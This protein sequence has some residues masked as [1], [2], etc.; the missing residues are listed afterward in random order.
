MIDLFI[1]Y[2]NTIF[3]ARF[4]RA[5]NGVPTTEPMR[6]YSISST[7]FALFL[8]LIS[9]ICLG[10]TQTV[11]SQSPVTFH[12]TDEVVSQGEIFL[13]L[14]S[15][16]Q[17][18]LSPQEQASINAQNAHSQG[19]AYLAELARQRNEPPFVVDEAQAAATGPL[20]QV[21]QWGPIVQWPFAFASAAT[22]PDGRII[23]WGA[24]N[25]RRFSGGNFT[26]ASIWDPATGQFLSRNHNDHP[27]FCAIPTM[28]EDGRLF[29][30]GG[31]ANTNKVST[32]D[33]RTNQW[34]RVDNMNTGRWYPGSVALPNGKVFTMLGRPGGP[35][36]EVWTEGQGWSLQTGANLNNGVLNY[37]GYQSTWLPYLHLMP[38]GN[39]LHSGPTTQMNILDPSGNGSIS[40]AG[41]TNS[42]YPKYSTGIMYDEGK[43]LVAGGAASSSSTAPGTNQAMIID[44]NGA[45][46][47]KTV[48]A[49]MHYARKF[50]NGVVLPTG[51]VLVIGGNTSGREFSDVGTIL[52]P[53][54]WNPTTQTW[55]EVA[56]MSVPR[57]YHSV[58]LLMTDGRVWSGGGGLCNCSADHMDHQVYSPPYLFNADGSPA[59]R[60]AITSGPAAATNGNVIT[61]QASADIQQFSLIKMSGTT[62]DLKSDLHYTNVP[63]TSPNSGE[64]QLT[65]HSNKNVLTPGFWMLFAINGQGTPSVAKVIQI[66]SSGAPQ[67]VSPGDQTNDVGD[68]VALQISANGPN[69]NAFT[70]SATG[71]PAG[72]SISSSGL[73]AGTVN[74]AGTYN[75]TITVQGNGETDSSSFVWNINT[76]P[77]SGSI[78]YVKLVADSEVNG[79]PWTSAAEFNVLDSNENVIDRSGWSITADSEET[80]GEDGRATNAIDGNTG[81]IWH[82]QWQA[83]DPPHPHQIVVDMGSGHAVKGFRYL[84]RQIGAINGT[85]AAY[86]FY[87]STDGAN[88]GSPVAQGTFAN[89]RDEK[90]VTF[91][92]TGAN[93]PPVLASPG[94]QNDAVGAT[95]SLAVSANDPDGD[96]MAFSATGLPTGLSIDSA[97]GQIG[98]T[99]SASGS[100]NVTVAV[101][102]G[103]GGSDSVSFTWSIY[104]ALTLS[105]LEAAPQP[106]GAAINYTAGFNNGSNPRFKWLF[107]DNTA[108]TAYSSSPSISHTFAEPGRYIVT[109]TATDDSGQEVTEQFAQLIHRPLTAQQPALSMSIVYETRAGNDRIWNV[110]PD[111]DTVSVTDAVT[112]QKVVE[113]AVGSNPR[114]LAVAPDGRI[115]VTNKQDASISIINAGS[116]NVVQTISLPFG[117]QPYGIAF[118]PNGSSAFVTLEAG[119]KLLKLNPNSGS[120]VGSVSVGPKPRH[121][122]ILADS[123][124]VYVSRFITPPLPGEET[125]NPQLTAGG[126]EVVVVNASTMS[127]Q[128]TITL[129]Y[130]NNPDADSN[131]RGIPN[132]LGPA[133]IS[134]DG[135]AAWIPSKKDNIGRGI[136]RDGQNLNF[137]HTVRSITSYIDLSTNQEDL[138]NRVDFDNGGVASSGQ[139]ERYG[140]FLFVA[141]ESS[142]EVSI[143]DA[144]TRSEIFR[145][146]V[147]RAPQGIV[148]SPDGLT[149]YVHNFM[150]RSVGVY[151]LTTLV[152]QGQNSI[153][154]LA[155]IDVVAGEQLSSQVLLGKQLFYDAKDPRLALDA[156]MSCAACHNEGEGDG[157]VWDLTGFGEGLRNTIDLNGHAGTGQ[158][159]LHWSANFDEVQDFEGQ[160]RSL[161]GGTGLMSDS[162]F[163]AG[164]RSQPLGD[165]KAGLSADLDALAAYVASL[166]T[167]A[168]SPYRN[169]NGSLTTAGEAGR[170]LFNSKDC[171][172]CHSGQGFTD[173]APNNQHDIGTIK[174]T[175]GSRLGSSLTGLDTP[176]L[177]GIWT[178]APYLHDGSAATL[179]DAVQAHNNV[180]LDATELTQIVSYL[181]QIDGNEPAP[182]A[183]NLPTADAGPDQTLTDSD[184]SGSENVTLDGSGSNDSDGTIVSYTW[185]SDTGVSIPNG[186]TSSANFAVGTHIVTL[187]VTDDDGAI[188]ID[189]VTI[190]VNAP[191][192]NAPTI[193]NPGAQNSTVGDNVSLTI[194][195]NDPDGDTLTYSASGLPAGL[196]IDTTTGTISGT[197]TTAES[198]SVTISVSDGNGGSDSTSFTWTIEEPSS[199]T[200][201]P[202][203]DDLLRN[204]WRNWSWAGSI[205][206]F[207]GAEVY[208]G[209]AAIKAD[210]NAYGALSFHN[211]IPVDTNQYKGF[212]FWIH[213]GSGGQNLKLDI[214]DN[215]GTRYGTDISV[216]TTAG[217]WTY[218][219]FAFAAMGNPTDVVRI[220]I[221][222][223]SS[224]AAST[225]YVDDLMLISDAP[226]PPP[227]SATTTLYDDLLRNGWQDYSWADVDLTIGSPVQE[228]SRAIGVNAE[229]WK[230]LYLYHGIPV[231]MSPYESVGF[232][233]HGGSSG[234]QPIVVKAVDAIGNRTSFVRITPQANAWSYHEVPL[235]AF[236]NPSDIKGL[237]WQNWSSGTIPQYFVDGIVF[238]E[239]ANAATSNVAASTE[240]RSG[241]GSIEG[242]I[243][244][245]LN[246]DTKQNVGEVSLADMMVVLVDVGANGRLDATD[247]LIARRRTDENGRYAFTDLADGNYLISIGT[248]DPRT[249]KSTA[250][251]AEMYTVSLR[252]SRRQTVQNIALVS[253]DLDG[254]RIPDLAEGDGDIDK[255]GLPNYADSDSDG[256]GIPDSVDADSI[257]LGTLIEDKVRE[258]EKVYLPLLLR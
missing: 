250:S 215:T 50:N 89:N 204:G 83:A 128:E 148:V 54:I 59:T 75:V 37:S 234:N 49:S 194:S 45:T 98:G 67:I 191:A 28:L 225:F 131:G 86:R 254:D 180:T 222:N 252:A 101:N 157:R 125:A 12:A 162:D 78:R 136:Q 241:S 40:P 245:D 253:G 57:N 129:Q 138:S 161:A 258:V 9:I 127:I 224:N 237:I 226:P 6:T 76:P 68:N 156:Y 197:P 18:S 48:I 39:I 235:S 112:R 141:L 117:S 82:T 29:V 256:D 216:A 140:A 170:T 64:Y 231:D 166:T 207:S 72:L 186:A 152:M 201:E 90:I 199:P 36:P 247:A 192:N 255:D 38:N 228:G 96:T 22:L 219:E 135:G 2:D 177:R 212:S 71:L 153:N 188:A 257:A 233:I 63:F 26:Y 209:S 84:P 183:N 176:T 85:I 146:D 137:D 106:V 124:R 46:P 97:S 5:Q 185:S 103:N 249:V 246:R 218:H 145:I 109:L 213:G 7:S 104:D 239:S 51:E 200:T 21:G 32:F 116:L 110:N 10:P 142:R 69:S 123:S 44:V 214:R 189:T 58:A 95:V 19:D 164:T 203:Y 34:T 221:K 35:Y 91:A 47:T 27:M 168:D 62:H 122:S 159:P 41:L 230:A 240:K 119:G 181:R 154:E 126:G 30:N 121:L 3:T 120:Q 143:I 211:A 14:I 8:G 238:I 33:Y 251:T 217:E 198:A 229:R 105:P 73:I 182:A 227:P 163:N 158:G 155:T 118:A 243:W 172:S 132:Y 31:D 174:P 139:F 16:P 15:A 92:L 202:I 88:W 13:P 144:Y 190:I 79:N 223:R 195:A 66:V 108:E 99:P 220:T 65:L 107:G 77:L 193:T 20:N 206:L 184:N 52:T 210:L 242:R 232:W 114:A 60:P 23:A 87:V 167:Y 100:Y 165:P 56:D 1:P 42:W 17:K 169:N 208:T 74:T 236:G 149:L 178:T 187:T 81:T 244:Y 179:A 151:D 55:R 93:Q 111:N 53:E 4:L 150:D 248:L 175:S 133:I 70:Y 11:F 113:I 171:A 102:D 173:S 94:D 115:W 196:S 130:S 25:V 134:P 147:G 61:V 160:I 43:I 205:N 24:N 80:V